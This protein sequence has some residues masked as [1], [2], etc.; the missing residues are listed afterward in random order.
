MSDLTDGFKETEIGPI[1]VDWEAVRL[2]RAE[3][4]AELDAVLSTLGFVGWREG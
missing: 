4:D 3:A 1:P 2:A